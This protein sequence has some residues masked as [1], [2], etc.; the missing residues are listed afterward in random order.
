MAK[1]IFEKNKKI[2]LN[3]LH[4]FG[5]NE[6]EIASCIEN[7]DIWLKSARKQWIECHIDIKS[8]SEK[9]ELCNQPHKKMCYVLNKVNDESLNIGGNCIQTLLGDEYSKIN[10]RFDNIQTRKNLEQIQKQ[11]PNIRSI[12]E[13]WD[14]FLESTSIIIPNSMS[15]EFKNIGIQLNEI[16]NEAIKKS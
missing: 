16:F 13:K 9:C 11:I 2:N 7:K 5:L 8:K 12:V 1:K 10:N 14:I 4:L 6:Y 15:V 3:E